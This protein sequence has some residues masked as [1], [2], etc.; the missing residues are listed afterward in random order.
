MQRR[1]FIKGTIG[2]GVG[3]WGI[4]SGSALASVLASSGARQASI[5][6]VDLSCESLGSPVVDSSAPRLSW[7]LNAAEGARG[8]VQSAYRVLVATNESLL[9]PGSPDLWDTGKV[10]S[11]QQLHVEYAGLN[12]SAGQR[13]YWRVEVWDG[14]DELSESSVVGW[15][16][17]GLL[18]P[19]NWSASWISNGKPLSDTDAGFYE[20]DPAPLMR[21]SFRISKPVRRARWY[22]TALG[23]VSLS[24]NGEAPSEDL[25]SPAWTQTDKTLYYSCHDITERLKEGENVLGA[26]LGNG[27]RN[28]L[29]LRMWGRI[30]IREHLPVGRP[31]FLSQLVIEYEDGT[32][33]RI[34]SDEA[35]RVS[36]GPLL[37]N[38]VYLG[39]TYDA[40]LEQSGWNAPGFDD[41][42]WKAVTIESE[43]Q[44]EVGQLRAMPMPPI[45]ATE[46]IAA[47]SSN[48]IEPGVWIVDL[49]QNFAGWV[50][51]QVEGPRGRTVRLRMG[52]LLHQDGTLNPM[53]AVAGQIKRNNAEGI[54]IGGP[55]APEIAEQV[56]TY[57]LKG[58][59]PEEYT[60]KFT[61]HG[62]RY[63]EVTGYP[64]SLPEGAIQG[65]RLNTDVEQVGH[66]QCSNPMFN[67]LNEVI[68]WTFLSNL[69]SVQS[70]CPAREKFQYG[71]DIVAS[72]EMAIFNYDM[73][74]FYAK[75]VGDFRDAAIDGWFTETAPYVGISAANYVEGAGPIGWGL[76]HPLLLDQLYRYY[77][78]LR[79]IEDHYEAARKWVDLLSE[80]AEGFII[81]R[82]IGDHESLDPKPIA[83]VA[84]AQFFQAASLVSGFAEKLGLTEDEIHYERLSD[85]IRSAFVGRFLEPGTGRFDS[86]TQAAQATALYM[87][88]VPE[89]E[90]IAAIQRMVNAVVADHDGHIAAGIFGTKYLLNALTET[91]HADV[92]YA[93]VGK[94]DYP[95][96]GHMMANGA[97]TLW[98]TWA[99]SDNVYSQNHPMFG[100]VCEWFY[101]CIGGIN[102]DEDANGFNR[103]SI[104]P[105]IAEDLEFADVIYE[106]VRGTVACRWRKDGGSL[107][108]DIE[109]P[110]NTRA[111]VRIPAPHPRGIREGGI[112]IS[113][114]EA[115]Q[116]LPQSEDGFIKVLVGSGRYVFT[117]PRL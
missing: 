91:G 113:D 6:P 69:F 110:P 31:Q 75:A 106:S 86:G 3:I 30:N 22:T 19:D 24:C 50:R 71:G 1:D 99:Q 54:S 96:W 25:L 55:G 13:C 117:A 48:E 18:S 26:S 114:V 61:F 84:T 29:P 40:R 104:E 37:R 88:L 2:A 16:E 53:T 23:Y 79:L 102:P 12:P 33:E 7:K 81:D 92:A 76:A 109:V 43:T 90:R 49:G 11:E 108:M 74:A 70:D 21:R 27:W 58:G 112:Q 32:S 17:M 97:T 94:Q 100:S 38:S 101:R 85:D 65:L 5:R 103:F 107:I 66:F 9:F 39:E 51:L 57:T 45:R 46:Q 67:Q 89:N 64:G 20:D 15:W 4:T 78:D 41:S 8:Q 42:S 60:P 73:A 56:I 87:S 14:N 68:Q 47:V 63:V 77:G 98:E 36:D 35:W 59:G 115:I 28:P 116:L 82:C 62:F 83:L 95:G 10:L 34:G 44:S 52:E 105:H 111:T 93:M 80:H 72:S